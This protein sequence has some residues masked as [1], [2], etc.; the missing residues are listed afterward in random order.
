[1]LLQRLQRRLAIRVIRGYRTTSAEAACVVSGSIPWELLAEARASM[2][3]RRIALRQQGITPTPS[4]VKAER[5]QSR[6][7]A[8]EKWKGRLA[9]PRAGHRA[10]GAIQPILE[11]WLDRRHGRLTFRLVQVLTGYGCFGEYLHEKAR[12]EPTTECHYCDADRD[13]AQ[14]TLEVCP[15]WA[16][17]RRVLVDKIG[18]DLFLPVVVKAMTGN[19][20]MWRIMV[21]FCE[22]VISQKEAAE[23]ERE[24]DPSS[25]P[26]RRRRRGARRRAFARFP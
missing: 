25:A 16:G 7:L 3:Q 19:R 13:T 5:H 1:M 4:A 22:V 20:E 10:V 26:V 11:D 21:S 24:D 23:R 17:Q 9:N 15:A 8:I 14:H 2:Y 6:Q 12:R 18:I